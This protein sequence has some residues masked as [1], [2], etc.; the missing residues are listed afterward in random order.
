MNE[1]TYINLPNYQSVDP[2]KIPTDIENILQN[3]IEAIDNLLNA[4]KTFQWSNLIQPM[5]S[6]GDELHN[7]W[8]TVSH[9][10]SVVNSDDLRD[11]F[12]ACLPLLS[13]YYT[14]ISHNKKL[15]NAIQ[16]IAESSEFA[17]LSKAQKKVIANDLRDFKLAGVALSDDKKK[18]FADTAKKLTELSAKFEQNL[19]DATQAWHYHVTDEK[20]LAGLPEITKQIAKK[21]AE[22]KQLDGWCLTLEM[23]IYHA[24]T[25][26]AASREIRKQFYEAYCTRASEEGPNAGQWDNG[27]LIDEILDLRYQMAT[28]LGFA[29]YADYSLATKMVEK[30]EQVEAFLSELRTKCLPKAK[31]E[32]EALNQ[33]AKTAFGI[34]QLKAWDINYYSEKLRQAQYSISQ[35]DLRP[36]FPEQNV[37]TGLFAIVNKLFGLTIKERNSVD[38]WHNDVRCFEVF[39][40]DNT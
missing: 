12:N 11:A 33:F 21:A 37:L 36:Y 5:E 16:S 22:Q 23:P 19:L 32:V 38:K 39:D 9:M 10:H 20:E 17:A 25:T 13:D 35:E 29:N 15:Y 40:K 27:T 34:E 30:P 2:K 6:L 14:R 24:V 18:I 31:Q 1:N 26:Y 8:S 4:S 7:Y 28:L 3:N